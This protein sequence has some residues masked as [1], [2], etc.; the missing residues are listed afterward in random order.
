MSTGP[1]TLEPV[2]PSLS[3]PPIADLRE[4]PRVMAELASAEL[5]YRFGI[6]ATSRVIQ[7][8]LASFLR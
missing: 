5:A 6:V 2:G 4:S 7:P 3:L 1:R 8:S